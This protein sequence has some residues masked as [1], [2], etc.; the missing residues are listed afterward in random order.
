MTGRQTEGQAGS[1]WSWSLGGIRGGLRYGGAGGPRG[2][3]GDAGG[4]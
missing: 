3:A 1:G 4:Q 2:A